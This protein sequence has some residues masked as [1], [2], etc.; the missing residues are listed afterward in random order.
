MGIAS[1]PVGLRGFSVLWSFMTDAAL[2]LPLSTPHSCAGGSWLLV[3]NHHFE[4]SGAV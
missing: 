2:A 4:L 3:I 1:S